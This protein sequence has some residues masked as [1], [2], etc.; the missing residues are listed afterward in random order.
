MV[1]KMVAA[2]VSLKAVMM[3]GNWVA[4]TVA[5]MAVAKVSQK[6]AS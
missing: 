1:A 3:A 4:T 2:K 6:A 5:R